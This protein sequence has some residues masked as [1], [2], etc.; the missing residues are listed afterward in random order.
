[1]TQDFLFS[2]D[3]KPEDRLNR[4]KKP[5]YAH[6]KE[7]LGSLKQIDGY[8]LGTDENIL[9][10]SLPENYTSCPNPFIP[11]LIERQNLLGNTERVITPFTEDVS[12]G[13]NDPLY[14]AHYYSTKVPP[15]AI[16][17][18]ILH[19]TRP[20]DLIFDG[21][22]GTGMTG[23]ATQICASEENR[24]SQ[25]DLKY[26]ERRTLLLDLSPA[27]N[28]IAEITNSL[29][30]ILPYLDNIQKLI[31]EVANEYRNLLETKHVGWPRGTVDNSL[32]KNN[33]SKSMS[34]GKIEYVVWSDVFRCPECA[35]EIIYWNLVFKGPRKSSPDELHCPK[36]NVL[37]TLR[38]LLRVTRT[39]FDHELGA[40]ITQA[41]QV[42][43]MINYSVGSRRFEKYPDDSDLEK[44]VSIEALPLPVS[45]PVVEMP[46]GFNTAQPRLSHGFT[47]CH[48]FYTRRNLLLLSVL[49]NRFKAINNPIERCGALFILTGTIQRVC[50]LNR[51]MPIHDRHVGPLSGTLYVS[52]LTA[53]IPATNYALDRI[54][55]L[56][57][58]L[59]PPTGENV[60]IS[61]QS[62]TDLRNI[63]NNIVDYIF[64]D[65]PFGGNLNYSELNILIEA[66]I[67]VRTKN[68]TEA[69]VNDIQ[70]KGLFEY[71]D[72]M[73]RSFSEFFRILKPGRWITIEFH[74]SQNSIWNAIQ[75]A[76]T[77]AGFIIADIRTLDKQKGTTKQLSY[78]LAVKQ[79]LIISAYKPDDVAIQKFEIVKGTEEGAWD[80]VRMH[81]RQL[82]V[83]V[84]S[85]EGQLELIPE[86]MNYLLF[87]RMVAF[88]IQNGVSV[89]LSA[90]EF[91]AGLEQRFSQREEMYFLTDQVGEYDHIRVNAKGVKQLE[92]FIIDESTA[93]QWLRNQLAQQPQTYQELHPKFF[94]EKNGWLKSEKQLEL[95][96]LLEQNYLHYDG[97]GAIPQQI[98]EWME[99]NEET[100]ELLK[101]Y[102]RE[103][104][105]PYVSSLAKD[106]WYV[107][108]P[109]RAQDLE[110]L[111]ERSLLKEFHDYRTLSG[112]SLKV[113]RIEALRAG[114]K[115][116]WENKDYETIIRVAEK[117]PE[118]ILQ[119]DS[120]L[121]MWYDQ[122]I[123]R[124]GK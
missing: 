117:I 15:Q 43:V 102:L 95:F 62:A 98:W 17:P 76:L 6:L 79:D 68:T 39:F 77:S 107:P 22:C 96:E 14:F 71:K 59:N 27:A 34:V 4:E 101:G 67:E 91:Y 119:E 48:H 56:R 28:F 111:R 65:P 121:L 114:F 122:A 26:E 113:F 7:T 87:D 53:E 82:P 81:L 29:G 108:D 24:N 54:D 90:A 123:T 42:P 93:I 57:R 16:V 97:E 40:T 58:C 19:Y 84:L 103:K 36:C 3:P 70:K 46:D 18:Y 89:P 105:S 100:R 35:E 49:W 104:P 69:V 30:L 74:N 8:P 23:V 37:L 99:R 120:K 116:S 124:L 80:F 38:N 45:T 13:K 11:N 20:G 31:N 44:I 2:Y 41:K 64:T 51:Y 86:R 83:Y 61:T 66:W 12:E 110:K 63:P 78:G 118:N 72:L 73:Y 75:E 112:R 5:K 25:S 33:L 21:F 109:N 10:L 85:K 92:L 32:R 47:H 1:M 55:D 60:F 52:Q 9:N 50:R 106:R 88:H 94:A 115:H